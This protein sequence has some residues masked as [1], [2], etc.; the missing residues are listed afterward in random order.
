VTATCPLRPPVRLAAAEGT[1]LSRLIAAAVA[2]KAV[3]LRTAELFSERKGR[4]DRVALDRLRRRP[5]GKPPRE[6]TRMPEG[7][8]EGRGFRPPSRMDKPAARD[9]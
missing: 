7:V 5:G 9:I 3:A 6:G 4:T 8:S 1:G 2:E